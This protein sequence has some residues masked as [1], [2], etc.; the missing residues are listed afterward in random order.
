MIQFYSEIHIKRKVK[1]CKKKVQKN[2]T[3]T[4]KEIRVDLR[5]AMEMQPNY[6]LNVK[7]NCIHHHNVV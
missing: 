4:E 3:G 5:T 1:E 2:G 7:I 6:I